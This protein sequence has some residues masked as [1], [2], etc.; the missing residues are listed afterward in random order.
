MVIVATAAVVSAG[1]LISGRVVPESATPQNPMAKINRQSAVELVRQGKAV[2]LDVRTDDEWKA[3]HAVG[4]VHFELARL[5]RGELPSI[6]KDAVVY[7]Y[8]RSGGRAAQAKTILEQR[9]YANVTNLG[10]LANWQALG[11]AVV[12]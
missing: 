9:G 5:Q 10:G 1:I 2:L 6:P 8:C 12:K 4:A 11:G 7:V 3:G